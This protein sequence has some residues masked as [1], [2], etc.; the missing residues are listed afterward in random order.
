LSNQRKITEIY[1]GEAKSLL[2]KCGETA[3]L[4]YHRY[5]V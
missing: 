3:R 5:F 2:G 4:Y 1:L